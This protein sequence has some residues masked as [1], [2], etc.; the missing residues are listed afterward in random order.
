MAC[1][2][3][4]GD[5]RDRL[6]TIACHK[7]NSRP[8]SGISYL[9]E[10]GLLS[11]GDAAG[12]AR[13]LHTA[14]GLSKR[15]IGAFLGRRDA[16]SEEVL[17]QL[18]R[19]HDFSGQ[20]LLPSLR[21]LLEAFHL[22]GESQKI[23]RICSCFAR[24]YCRQNCT[25]FASVDACATLC[26]ALLMLNTLLHNPSA[27][28]APP[29]VDQLAEMAEH[30][31]RPILPR[32]RLRELYNSISVCPF[33]VPAAGAADDL[34]LA[35]RQSERSGWLTERRWE[36]GRCRRL[37]RWQR[38]W[39]VLV[40]NHLCY[41]ASREAHLRDERPLG[42]LPLVNLRLQVVQDRCKRF[43]FELCGRRGPVPVSEPGGCRGGGLLMIEAVRL[44]AESCQDMTQWM[45]AI[46]TRATEE[47]PPT[48]GLRSSGEIHEG[49]AELEGWCVVT[50]TSD[51]Q[52]V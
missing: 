36:A 49:S 24:H 22:P 14:A 18:V 10:E 23:E 46:T 6:L 32:S 8:E 38:R 48:P 15:A 31:G 42:L 44:S 17:A 9:K 3:P 45:L 25:E 47:P 1:R 19:R 11:E 4:T 50:G 7:F 28:G 37:C 40:R 12:V 26:T 51:Q 20:P 2:A 30:E 5:R 52:D 21:R 29:S 13:F 39:F 41:F 33:A 34:T 43:C 35:L 16:F 27:R